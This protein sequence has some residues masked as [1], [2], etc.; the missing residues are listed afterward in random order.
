MNNKL[1][2]KII[3]V[4]AAVAGLVGPPVGVEA[5][6][7]L[8]FRPKPID[9]YDLPHEFYYTWGINKDITGKPFGLPVTEKI[10]GATLTFS[11]IY[12]WKV[13]D[14]D[15]LYIHLLDNPASGVVA[16]KDNQLGGDNFAGKGVVVGVWNDPLGGSAGKTNL[17]YEFSDALL[18]TLNAYAATSVSG[19]ANFGFGIDPDC[20]YY[21]R[22]IT[23]TIITADVIHTPPG[24]PVPAPGAILL[25]GIGVSLVGWLRRRRTL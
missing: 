19:K 9:L 4:I 21:N 2:M 6:Q 7:T 1:T 10:I 14:N 3:C 20:H 24:V 8:S 25:G 5:A 13:E 12:D 11:K 17:V 22:G 16:K 18:V 15:A 23:F